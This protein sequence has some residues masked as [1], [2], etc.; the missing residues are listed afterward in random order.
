MEEMAAPLLPFF[1]YY[2]YLR[3]WKECITI[4]YYAGMKKNSIRSGW[5]WEKVTI[6]A[7]NNGSR[8]NVCKKMLIFALATENPPQ[9]WHW[10]R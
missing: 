8:L 9:T 2:P 5:I 7:K 10:K 1:T 4:K 6:F 3:R